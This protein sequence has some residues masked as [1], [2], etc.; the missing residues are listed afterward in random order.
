MVF[1]KGELI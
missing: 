1:L